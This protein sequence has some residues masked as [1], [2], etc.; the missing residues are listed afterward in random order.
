MFLPYQSIMAFA[1]PKKKTLQSVR[2]VLVR[3]SEWAKKEINQT[4]KWL[5]YRILFPTEF[6]DVFQVRECMHLGG[7]N[8]CDRQVV[9]PGYMQIVGCDTEYIS[10][11]GNNDVFVISCGEPGCDSFLLQRV[12]FAFT[13]AFCC[14]KPKHRL[15][16]AASRLG[17]IPAKKGKNHATNRF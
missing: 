6:R 4:S 12:V 2:S 17:W 11:K 16:L 15:G 10:Y 14:D 5:S 7:Q 1:R 8:S 3:I 13:S 9:L